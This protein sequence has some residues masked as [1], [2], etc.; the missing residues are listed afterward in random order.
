MEK[1][2]KREMVCELCGTPFVT[3]TSDEEANEEFLKHFPDFDLNDVGV[4]CTECYN[5]AMEY[6]K[7]KKQ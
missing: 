2:N 3:V 4:V 5:F 1:R 7:Y 6:I